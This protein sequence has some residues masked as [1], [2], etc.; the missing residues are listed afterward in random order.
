[1]ARATGALIPR[2]IVATA[3]A[4]AVRPG[5]WPSALRQLRVLAPDRWWARRPFLPVPDRDWMAFRMTTAY[6]DP[7]APLVADDVVTWLRW[8]K[9]VRSL[10]GTEG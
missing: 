3:A 4:V 1:M 9:S 2:G 5:L 8:S 10:A 6:G 7:G